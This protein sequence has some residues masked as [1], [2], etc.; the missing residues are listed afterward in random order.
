MLSSFYFAGAGRCYFT[1]LVDGVL[2]HRD[3]VA[4]SIFI[5]LLVGVDSRKGHL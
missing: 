2:F 5:F 4:A 1:M 3:H